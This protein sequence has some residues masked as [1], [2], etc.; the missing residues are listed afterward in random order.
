MD[1]KLS[2]ITSESIQVLH[3]IPKE[4]KHA[5][6]LIWDKTSTNRSYCLSLS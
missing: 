3:D 1:K 6:T 5:D 4:I 2:Q